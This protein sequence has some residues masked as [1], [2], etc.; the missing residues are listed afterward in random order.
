MPFT[1]NTSDLGFAFPDTKLIESPWDEIPKVGG[2]PRKVHAF[3]D[4]LPIRGK[5]DLDYL[6]N[7]KP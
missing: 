6:Q 4:E 5:F 3:S 2:L 7:L 1:W